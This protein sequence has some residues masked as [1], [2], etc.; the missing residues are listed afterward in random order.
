MFYQNWKLALF[1]LLMMPL[2]G[3]LAKSLGKRIG[4]LHLKQEHPLEFLH[5]FYLKFLEFKND[6]NISEGKY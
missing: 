3:G 1:A 6:K 2:A 5:L 4:K